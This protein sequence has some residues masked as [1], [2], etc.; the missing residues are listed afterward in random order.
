MSV[1][2]YWPLGFE[3]VNEHFSHSSIH[4]LGVS[5]WM[6]AGLIVANKVFYSKLH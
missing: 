1:A 6:V 2:S 5:L 3:Q 4:I